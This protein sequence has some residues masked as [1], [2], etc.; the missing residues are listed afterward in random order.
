MSVTTTVDRPRPVAAVGD[1]TQLPDDRGPSGG[2][3]T[4]FA[5]L[6]LTVLTVV[7]AVGLGRLFADGSYIGAVVAAAVGTHAVAWAARRRALSYAAAA[8]GGVIV[9]ALVISWFVLPETTVVGIP[10]PH[11]FTRAGH[12][13][14][15]SYQAFRHVV[16]PAPVSHGF[17]I[18]AV[19]GI[20]LAALLADAAAFLVRATFEATIPSFTLFVF[21][22]TLGTARFRTLAI[23]T[24]LGALL[25]FVLLHEEALDSIN[26][27]WFASRARRGRAALARSGALLA[28]VAV[29]AAVLL[30]PHMPGAGAKALIKWRGGDD[31]SHATRTTVSPLV[32][33][34]TRLVDRA[35]VEVFTVRSSE[36]AYWRL[37]SL[38]RFDGEIW[39]SEGSYKK[40]G[41]QLDNDTAV[42]GTPVLQGFNV[43]QLSSIWL[44][45][46]YEPR[47]VEGL[48]S[49]SYS[50][51]SSSVITEKATTDGDA[52]QVESVVPHYTA[53][54]LAAAPAGGL[55][56]KAAR[57]YLSLPAVSQRVRDLA[58][59]V[60]GTGTPYAKA[61]ALQD[62]FRSGRFTYDLHV[63][64]GHNEN[65]LE[66]FL[67]V[68]RRGYCEQFAGSYGVLARL[69]G[70][71]TRIA[72][73]FTTGDVGDDGLFHVRDLNAH[74][75]PEVYLSGYGW[76][77]FE[78]TPG[79]GAPGAEDYTGLPESQANVSNPSTATTLGSTATTEAPQQQAPG[80][81]QTPPTTAA[82]A[83][84]PVTPP[85]AASHHSHTLLLVIGL[86]LAFVL[87]WVLGIPAAKRLRR[88]RR[89]QAAVDAAGRVLVSW[90]EAVEAL[91]LAK[92]TPRRSETM[93]EYASRA[94][95]QVPLTD[96]PASAL[97]TLADD[98]AM[99]SYAAVGPGPESLTRAQN[100][101]ATIE[102]SVLERVGT[103]TRLL[104]TIDPRPLVRG[105][106]ISRRRA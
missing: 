32:N 93:A 69:V 95:S 34:R 30:G 14:S 55:A 39:S 101:A 70:L 62:F 43:S 66:R 54:E 37:T 44:P 99:A 15:Q 88:A 40:L 36:R 71:P 5:T 79:R 21:T 105:L 75:W 77:A 45:A 80:Q 58:V 6:A 38:D 53:G 63:P 16:A 91:S 61:K 41:S 10:T 67:F 1:D 106:R 97:A 103:R 31:N 9:G 76:V 65:A 94:A 82:P 89:R 90:E 35:D 86:V 47:R 74:A 102:A 4:I 51:D 57:E 8:V 46:A 85:K 100:A 26:A 56:T 52:Y 24:Y 42:N 104:S 25:L 84:P 2:D 33:I 29:L 48:K 59:Q 18:A 72:V 73:G 19:V 81:T 28:A 22:A 12:E 20:V 23:A 27:S 3:P 98:A 68:T 17:V 11:T 60:A 7:V 64:A 87:A 49:L 96:A 92:A 78:P 50:P 13:L 83:T